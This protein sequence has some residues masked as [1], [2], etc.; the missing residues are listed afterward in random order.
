M[1]LDAGFV[2]SAKSGTSKT[3]F[4]DLNTL[5][6]RVK[7]VITCEVCVCYNTFTYTL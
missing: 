4:P 2:L 1:Q 5:F 3:N 6:I 7:P